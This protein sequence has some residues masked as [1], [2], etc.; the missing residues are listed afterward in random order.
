MDSPR[1]ADALTLDQLELFVAVVDAGSFSG[2][3]RKLRRAQSAVSYGIKRLEELL[4]VELLERSLGGAR[5]TL[6]GQ[7]LLVEARN[8][9]DQVDLLRAAGRAFSEKVEPEVSISLTLLYPLDA[10]GAITREL[11]ERFPHTTLRVQSGNLGAAE[12]D[13]LNGRT[14][15]GVS[16]LPDVPSELVVLPCG[17]ATLARVVSPSHPLAKHRG[18]ISNAELRKHLQLVGMDLTAV[19]SKVSFN[20]ISPRTWRIGDTMIRYQMLLAGAGW[21]HLPRAWV[22]EDIAAGRLLELRHPKNATAAAR[23]APPAPSSTMSAPRTSTPRLSRSASMI[24]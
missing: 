4:G 7:N 22:A 12:Q 17:Q 18:A 6:Q 14:T 13:V 1:Y 8:V 3:A 23:A 9:I 16:G 24:P 20:V 5:P 19:T 21:T 15:L 11:R 2:A 10:F